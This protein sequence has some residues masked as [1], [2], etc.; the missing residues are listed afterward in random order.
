MISYIVFY[1][2][3]KKNYSKKSLFLFNIN[4][5]ISLKLIS[6]FLL[7]SLINL[8]ASTQ[9]EVDAFLVSQNPD[10][11]SLRTRLAIRNYFTNTVSIKT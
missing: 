8:S 11:L 3:S 10:V 2:L 9:D 4:E 1:E 7:L 6:I 5:M